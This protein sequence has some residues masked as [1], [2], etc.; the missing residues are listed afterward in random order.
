MCHFLCLLRVSRKQ[1]LCLFSTTWH[2]PSQLLANQQK[3]YYQ[4]CNC[5]VFFQIA[6]NIM[7]RYPSR[8]L[9]LETTTAAAAATNNSKR[10]NR[11]ISLQNN[12]SES[13]SSILALFCST[14]GADEGCSNGFRWQG[15]NY[16]Q[17]RSFTDIFLRHRHFV[18]KCIFFKY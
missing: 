16:L 5:F 12:E 3:Q 15:F 6:R 7:P 2:S 9:A 1:L 14:V 11:Q 18:L 10:S 4:E 8:R 17:P 13:R